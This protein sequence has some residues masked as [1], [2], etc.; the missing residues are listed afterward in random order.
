M[1]T[2]TAIAGA[3][4]AFS[5]SPLLEYAPVVPLAIAGCTFAVLVGFDWWCTRF[6]AP[7]RLQQAI[8]IGEVVSLVALLACLADAALTE[9]ANSQRCAAIQQDMLSAHPRL[10]NGPAV[11]EALACGPD[12][13]G[14]SIFV[15]PTD[16]EKRAGHPLPYGGYPPPLQREAR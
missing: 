16:R 15:P 13:F 6:G 10:A 14:A 11:F 9:S 1:L 3:I 7:E 2:G 4:I 12:G 8:T 5:L